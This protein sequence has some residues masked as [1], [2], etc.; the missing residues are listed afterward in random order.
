MYGEAV[1]S[2]FMIIIAIFKMFK[3][4]FLQYFIEILQYNV[5]L[6]QTWIFLICFPMKYSDFSVKK[7]TFYEFS[8][9]SL[10]QKV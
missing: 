3:F 10:A 6:R 4:F 1:Y 8:A 5:Y 7:Q 9:K 2:N